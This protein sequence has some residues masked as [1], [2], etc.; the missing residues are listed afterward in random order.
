MPSFFPGMRPHGGDQ[1]AR[2]LVVVQLALLGNVLIIL[3]IFA[4]QNAE[5]GRLETVVGLTGVLLA[6]TIVAALVPWH[7]M[8]LRWPILIG[9]VDLVVIALLRDALFDYQR[10]VSI[11]AIIPVIWL[12]YEFGRAV[13]VLAIVL[14]YGV[15]I[16][17]FLR[18]GE[19]PSIPSDWSNALTPAVTGSIIAIAVNVAAALLKRQSTRLETAR[20]DLRVSVA[21]GIDGDIALKESVDAGVD[22]ASAALTVMDTVDAGITFYAPDGSV[23][24]ANA[25]ARELLESSGVHGLDEAPLV[26]EGESTTPMSRDDYVL[27]LAS[28]GELVTRRAYRIGVGA[29]ERTV[30]S[31]SQYVRRANG[32]LLGTVIATHD[33]TPLADAIRSRDTFLETVSHELRTPLTSIIGYLEVIEDA[34]EGRDAGIDDELAIVQRNSQRLLRLISDLLTTAEG[35]ATLERR[36]TDISELAAK[37]LEAARGAA[38]RRGIRIVPPV[39]APVIAEVDADHI[40]DVFDKILS[41][42][43]TFTAAGGTISLSVE[44]SGADAVVRITDTGT[45]MT[46]DDASHVFERF[47][48]SSTTRSDVVAGA[49]L[50]LSTA[51]VIVDA[52][53]G[54]I[55]ASSELGVGTTLEVRLPLHA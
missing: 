50:G 37:A 16:Y 47:F 14:D 35:Q 33:V 40:T 2:I 49:G 19:W 55:T 30:M 26:F 43:V 36:S 22:A 38:V 4:T 17:P 27:A 52:H 42:A 51:K 12:S 39:L 7:R 53:K 8:D 1:R 54:T 18:T 32:E 31:S 13:V 41:N 44:Q 6:A 24:L 15:A 9:V 23:I 29:E 10:S 28:R 46:D 34:V 21:E 11:L 20:E 45:G 25:T 48:R 3:A 5:A